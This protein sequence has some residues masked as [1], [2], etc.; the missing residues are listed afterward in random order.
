MLFAKIKP[1]EIVCIVKTTDFVVYF[2]IH[3]LLVVN[4]CGFNK[5]DLNSLRKTKK[6][7]VMYEIYLDYRFSLI[8]NPPSKN[9]LIGSNLDSLVD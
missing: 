8:F 2:L 3:M 7:R 6:P 1:I 4:E 9:P 5:Q